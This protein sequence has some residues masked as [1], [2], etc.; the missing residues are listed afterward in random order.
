M[1]DFKPLLRGTTLTRLTYSALFVKYNAP[2]I[3]EMT[4]STYRSF[5]RIFAINTA[6]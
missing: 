4:R 6:V 1:Y 3:S 5:S 2:G